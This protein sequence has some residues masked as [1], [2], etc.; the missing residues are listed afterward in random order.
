[1][2][3][4]IT[5]SGFDMPSVKMIS[6]RI[7]R[8]EQEC[9]GGLIAIVFALLIANVL[10]RLFKLPIYWID[11]LAIFVMIW[12]AFVGT[13]ISIYHREHIAVTLLF[14]GL[15]ERNRNILRIFV[16]VLLLTFLLIFAGLLWR[17]FDPILLLKS[18]SLEAFS[19]VDF[20]FIY[21]EPTTT[22]GVKK[23]WFWMIMPIFCITSLIHAASNLTASI[24]TKVNFVSQESVEGN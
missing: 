21:Q 16:D 5:Q 6:D 11:E 9:A 24:K 1:M 12:A 22:I 14:D 23:I 8:L 4:I 19:Q 13:S 20:N 18:Q 7:V 2:M 10:T 15:S 17:W 3:K